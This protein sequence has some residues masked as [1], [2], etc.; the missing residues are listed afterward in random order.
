MS[1]F[2]K[3]P[4]SLYQTLLLIK[5]FYDET[6]KDCFTYRSL[7]A[8]WDKHRMYDLEWHTVERALRKL[9][10]L[11]YLDRRHYKKGRKKL[12]VFCCNSMTYSFFD[13]Y[14]KHFKKK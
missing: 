11:H 1:V 9:S 5:R 4:R 12:V 13:W 10:E 6:S 14:D 8:F 7:R 2:L 3:L